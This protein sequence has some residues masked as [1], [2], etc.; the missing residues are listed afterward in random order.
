MTDQRHEQTTYLATQLRSE[1]CWPPLQKR[2]RLSGSRAEVLYKRDGDRVA[3]V[4]IALAQAP[5]DERQEPVRDTHLA[6]AVR[7]HGHSQEVTQERVQE[8]PTIVSQV[9]RDYASRLGYSDD[10]FP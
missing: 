2:I 5:V 6:G 9:F 8:Q 4:V 7:T 3:C 1:G 10:Q